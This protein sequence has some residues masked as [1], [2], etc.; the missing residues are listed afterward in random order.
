H[1]NLIVNNTV[2]DPDGSRSALQ[3]ADGADGNVVFNNILISG[4]AGLEV[5][6]VRGLV[7]D[8]N[9]VSSFAGAAASAHEASA[10]AA[11]LFVAPG[12]P[13]QTTRASVAAV[14][15]GAAARALAP[16]AAA[17]GWACSPPWRASRARGGGEARAEIRASARGVD[18]PAAGPHFGSNRDVDQG[19]RE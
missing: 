12:R 4:V 3:L 8:Y 19:R 2:Y 10:D 17:G 18:G 15:V 13:S 9:L 7:H 5:R 1:D 6:A 16:G 11:S 14:A